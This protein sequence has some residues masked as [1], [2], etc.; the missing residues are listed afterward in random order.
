[1]RV[2]GVDPGTIIA[3]Y[4]IIDDGDGKQKMVTYGVIKSSPKLPPPER[5]SIL[6]RGL[7]KVLQQY[8][9]TVVA[10]EQPFVGI[11]ISSALAIGQAQAMAM[12]VAANNNI[13]VFEYSP[14]TV[15]Q[16]VTSYGASSKGQIQQSVK[17][18]LG[19]AEIPA[20]SDAADALA[21]AI[22]H[23]SETHIENLLGKKSFKN[24]RTR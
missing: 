17:L 12:L 6:Y 7:N 2:L 8:R 9:P 22:C 11:N 21:I 23:L 4:G 3:G 5:L 14:A 15:K 20:P 18:L 16:R 13:P 10:I 19:L 24:R 1:M